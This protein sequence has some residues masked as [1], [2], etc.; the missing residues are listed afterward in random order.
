MDFSERYLASVEE[1]KLRGMR[2]LEL[3]SMVNKKGSACM[4]ELEARLMEKGA[5]AEAG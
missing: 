4:G 5:G 3:N 2:E 1:A